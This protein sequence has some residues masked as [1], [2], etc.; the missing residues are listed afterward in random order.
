MLPDR[1]DFLKDGSIVLLSLAAPLRAACAQ[2]Q[3]LPRL[4]EDDPQARKLGYHHSSAKVDRKRFASH[5]R[6][7]D[8][9]DCLHYKGRPRDPWGPCDLFPGKAVNAK[10]WCIEFALKKKA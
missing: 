9:D 5:R 10:G 4:A 1:R 2:A 8:C 7:Q 6:G 3:A